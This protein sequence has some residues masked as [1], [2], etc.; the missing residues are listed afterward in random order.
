MKS[1]KSL[2]FSHFFLILFALF[3]GISILKLNKNRDEKIKNN[4]KVKV[5]SAV[6]FEASRIK[7]ITETNR[8]T[9]MK[10]PQKDDSIS[11]SVGL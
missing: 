2:K 8:P 1:F 11:F 6:K 5:I 3:L 10:S 7:K 9:N 4:P